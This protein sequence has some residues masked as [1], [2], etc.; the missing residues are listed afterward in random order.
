MNEQQVIEALG[1]VQ[2]PDSRRDVVS[3]QMVRSVQVQGADVFLTLQLQPSYA[4]RDE[5]EKRAR[6]EL[7]KLPGVSEITVRFE[8]LTPLRQQ[9]GGNEKAPIPGVKNLIA[10]ASGKGGVGKTTVAVNLAVAMANLGARVGLMDADVY[11]PNVPVMM[12][13][14]EQPMAEGDRI[15]PLQNYGVRMISMGFL[16]PG[17]RP[18]IWRGPMLHSVIQQFIRNV[19]WGDLDYLIVD[20][21]P[22]TGDVQLTLLQTVPITGAVVVTTP[23]DVALEDA[24][25]AIQMFSQV[26]ADVLGVVENMSYFI[27]PHCSNR[28]DVFSHGGGERMAEQYKVPF[29]GHIPL[30]A[31]VR[32]G[33]DKG[34]PVVARGPEAPQ[35]KAFYEVA[36][37]VMARIESLHAAEPSGPV[38]RIRD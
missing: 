1:R 9:P 26:K 2:E 8:T 31:D 6:A 34:V 17:D 19:A 29:L 24:R 33:G 21:P 35:A 27:C 23:S 15:L 13:I 4:H 32:V 25:K 14:N 10:V 38:V 3:L 36:R 28:I 37:A 20:L 7:G 5:L 22:G 11:G 16:N 12:A 18:V 30:D